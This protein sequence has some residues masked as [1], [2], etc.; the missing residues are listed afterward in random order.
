MDVMHFGTP[1]WLRQAVGDP[2][3]PEALEDLAGRM[4]ARYRGQVR[5]WCPVNE[6]L[7]CALFAGDMGFWPPHARKWRGYMPVLSRVAMATSRAIRVPSAAKHPTRPSSCATRPRSTRR[8]TSR[9]NLK[10]PCG[11]SAGSS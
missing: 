9:R 1:L 3:F 8:S 5:A 2:E 7:V 4:A 6:P 10:S 11:T